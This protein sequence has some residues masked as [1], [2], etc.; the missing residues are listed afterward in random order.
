MNRVLM[1]LLLKFKM[2]VITDYVNLLLNI[3]NN[4][5]RIS[6]INNWNCESN[7]NLRKL[8]NVLSYRNC[9]Y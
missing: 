7:F 1:F 5:L 9:F 2:K 4:F 3:L 8:D 6:R